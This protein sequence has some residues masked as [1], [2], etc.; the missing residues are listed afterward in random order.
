MCNCGSSGG[1]QSTTN[2]IQ[3]LNAKTHP[4]N[5]NC[6]YTLEILENWKVMLEDIKSS[7]TEDLYNISKFQL[8]SYLGYIQSAINYPKN[9]CFYENYFAPVVQIAEQYDS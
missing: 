8:N 6:A 5:P 3:N 9:I 2:N 4:V 1:C 7:G